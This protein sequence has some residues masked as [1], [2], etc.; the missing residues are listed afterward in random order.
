M[1]LLTQSDLADLSAQAACAPRLRAHHNI[2]AE[3]GDAIQRLAIAMEPDT[4][5]RPHR[6]PGSPELLIMLSGA[7]D[8]IEFD[9]AGETVVA[10]HRLSEDGARVFEMPAGTWHSVVSLE[11]GSVVFEIKRGP[12]LPLPAADQAAWAPAEGDARVADMLA[13]LRRCQPGDRFA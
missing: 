1:K 2:H 12:Y 4:Y 9:A 6:H 7:L 5:V 8:W 3:L 11:P 10:R 13:F